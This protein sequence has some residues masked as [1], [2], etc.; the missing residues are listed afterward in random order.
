MEANDLKD[1]VLDAQ[2]ND[3]TQCSRPLPVKF[4]GGQPTMVVR[5]GSHFDSQCPSCARLYRND[6]K[7]VVGSG[8]ALSER[9]S[10]DESI[11]AQYEFYFLTL[12]APSFG[13]VHREGPSCPCGVS[14]PRGSGFQGVAVDPDQYDYEGTVRWNALSSALWAQTSKYLRAAL[15]PDFAFSM[16]NE[17]QQRGAIH[18]HVLIRVPAYLDQDK[19]LEVLERARTYEAQGIGWGQKGF[20]VQRIGSKPDQVKHRVRYIAKALSYSVKDLSH[21]RPSKGSSRARH[22][23]FER[24]D[25]AARV[26]PCV[27]SSGHSEHHCSGR[28]HG[29][30]GF[31]GYM[32]TRSKNWSL[33]GLSLTKVRQDRQQWAND[34]RIEHER[35]LTLLRRARQRQIQEEEMRY[36]EGRRTTS[37]RWVQR[38]WRPTET[39]ERPAGGRNGSE[40]EVQA[41]APANP[42]KARPRSGYLSCIETLTTDHSN[43]PENGV[44][45]QQPNPEPILVD[46]WMVDP[47]TGE[48]LNA[49]GGTVRQT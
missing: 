27:R 49:K 29:R 46:G 14:H 43:A 23:H 38:C 31:G 7:R 48:I 21:A 41:P 5:C 40:V 47:E 12:T 9:D 17:W 6:V 30:W 8:C 25:R 42:S 13:T 15:G 1:L 36:R 11:L 35:K 3:Q 16:S 28:G 39:K 26:V 18:K 20:D 45:V 33:V 44:E 32:A 34:Q 4:E 24:L 37:R 22:E 2:A 19:V 10:V